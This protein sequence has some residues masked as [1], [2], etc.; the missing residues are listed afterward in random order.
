MGSRVSRAFRNFNLENRAHREISKSKP[1]AAPHHPLT[2]GIIQQI[3]ENPEA[4]ESINKK[5]EHLL[6]LL[7]TVYVESKDPPQLNPVKTKIP[8]KN[9]EECRPCKSRV[10]GNP[11]GIL[12]IK[13]IPKG[14][15]S[16][17]EALTVLNNHKRS[18]K[19]WTPNKIAQ[20]Y[21]LDLKDTKALLE[22]FILFD[23]KIIPPKTEDK[24]QIKAN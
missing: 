13:G 18:P 12:D 4:T 19:S 7:K 5:N 22:F 17:V 2:K 15:L 8:S 14:K 21:S 24:K 11:Y 9:E 1:S 6:S 16:I 20:E 23:V 3:K 10:V